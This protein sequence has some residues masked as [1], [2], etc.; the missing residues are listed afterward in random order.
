MASSPPPQRGSRSTLDLACLTALALLPAA[1]A[2]QRDAPSLGAPRVAAQ[3]ATGVVATP[4][5]FVAAGKATEWVAERLGVDDPRASRLALV[6]AWVGAGLATAG[7]PAAVGARGPGRGRY[8]AAV[9]GVVAGGVGSYLL[10]RV[11]D[12]TGDGPRR[13]CRLGCAIAAAAVFALPSV[14]ATVAYNASRT[15]A[16]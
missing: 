12:R 14:G 6:G 3:L 16:R 4:V 7:T 10:V 9:G 13:P 15:L 5:G 8:A 1:A 2:A 11:N